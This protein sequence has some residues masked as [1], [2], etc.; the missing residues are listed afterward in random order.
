MLY[1]IMIVNVDIF[2]KSDDVARGNIFINV[3]E[4]VHCKIS[5]TDVVLEMMPF[6]FREH[7]TSLNDDDDH[8]NDDFLPFSAH[9]IIPEQKINGYCTTSDLVIIKVAW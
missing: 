8:N 5:D 6:I 7:L 2:N 1:I 3:L 9:T 4:C